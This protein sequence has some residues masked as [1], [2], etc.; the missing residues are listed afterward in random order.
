M[1]NAE[2]NLA[3]LF[4]DVAGSTELYQRYGDRDALASIEGCLA[5]LKEVTAGYR[6]RVVKMIGDELMAVFTSAED[7]LVAAC[8]MQWS[9]SELPP[10]GTHQLAVRIGF[11]FGPTLEQAGDIFGDA[12]N[13]AARLAEIA[14]AGQILTSEDT[15][16]A[17]G[18]PLSVRTRKLDRLVLRGMTTEM[19]LVEAI[20]Q[21]SD[22]ITALMSRTMRKSSPG[23]PLVLRYGEQK[24]AVGPERP[25][26]TFG[27]DE[28][29]DV[30][31]SN[32]RAS[33]VHAIIEWRRDKFILADQSTNGTFVAT[34]G[35]GETVLRREEMTLLGRGLVS[36]G[37]PVVPGAQGLLEFVCD[38]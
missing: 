8:E 32:D 29:N 30:V 24:I 19:I 35:A 3:T 33:R 9:V 10:L 13:I 15:V 4:V 18:K 7:A 17:V 12:V 27:R 37:G 2:Q 20:W 5:V 1:S 36:F 28:G 23:K 21:E 16:S 25:R 11:H 31:V 6:G 26:V 38:V 34:E 22:D 14:K